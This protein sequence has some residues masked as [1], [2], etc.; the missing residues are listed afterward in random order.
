MTR[1]VAMRLRTAVPGV[2]VAVAVFGAAP[3]AAVTTRFVVPTGGVTSA[4]CDQGHPCTAAY[5][6]NGAGSASGDLVHVDPGTSALDA[7]PIA[8][9]RTLDIRGEAGSARPLFQSTADKQF[10][11]PAAAAGT[12]IDHVAFGGKDKPAL[13]SE[14]SVSVNDVDVTSSSGC[15]ELVG[16]NVSITNST[17]HTSATPKDFQCLIASAPGTVTIH[18]LEI[19]S[20]AT[21][22]FLA[23]GVANAGNLSVDDV[24]VTSPGDGLSFG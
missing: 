9:A 4:P 21:P 20:S 16:D 1:W 2:L 15:A 10:D 14:G 19:T 17:L 11:V 3:A 22:G 18:N 5:V 12:K 8:L 7:A 6:M 24:R 13:Q 23:A